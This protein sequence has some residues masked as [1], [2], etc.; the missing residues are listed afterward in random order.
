VIT[1]KTLCLTNI[2]GP[3]VVEEK[4]AFI[5]WLYN[6]DFSELDDCI[7][8]GDFSL[9]KPP[10]DRNRDGGNVNYMFLFSD[11]IHHL[12]FAE[13]IF[14]AGVF[15]RVICNRILFLKKIDWVLTS[16]T[17]AFSYLDTLVQVLGRPVCDH[18]PFV[19]SIGT[20]VP[21]TK[22]LKF[23]NYWMDFPDFLSVVQLHWNT[24]PYFSNVAKTLN[25]KFRQVRAGLKL[26]S[27]DL[28]K[29]G[30]LVT[31]CNFVLALPDCLEDLRPLS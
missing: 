5:N 10:E 30:K 31:N 2:Y 9:I 7:L 28:S 1:G 29:L 24:S 6:F 4:V 13:I 17:W 26:W 12:D 25:A 21:K 11:L 27:R 18:T 19:A 3:S 20:N 15:L 22:P 8:A 16:S 23:K 14:R